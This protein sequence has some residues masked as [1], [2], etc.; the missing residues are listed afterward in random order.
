MAPS[1]PEPKLG[2]K[3]IPGVNWIGLKSLHASH[4]YL[5][6]RSG[7]FWCGRWRQ[8][9]KANIPYMMWMEKHCM[10]KL[11][12]SWLVVGGLYCGHSRQT[13]T[14]G[15]QLMGWLTTTPMT[16]VN[17]ALPAGTAIGKVGTITLDLI[18]HGKSKYF[19]GLQWRQLYKPNELHPMRRRMANFRSTA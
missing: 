1:A 10:D 12:R 13:L 6:S 18:Q 14:I 15:P 4:F 3:Q 16:L 7:Q 11:R 2:S 8:H 5:K 19:S 17:F 9:L